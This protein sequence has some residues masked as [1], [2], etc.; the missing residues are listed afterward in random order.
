MRLL[1]N[2]AG[3]VTL[4]PAC[5]VPAEQ[6]SKTLSINVLGV[7]HGVRAFVPRMLES[8]KPA[9]IAN[10][11]S[12]GALAM[13]PVQT[14]YIIS[15]HAVLSFT[16]CLYLEMALQKKPIHVSAVVPGLVATRIFADA[17][18][19]RSAASVEGHRAYMEALLK[20]QGLTPREAGLRILEGIAAG[21][22]WVS[23]HPELTA[24]VAAARAEYLS[25]QAEPS[26]ASQSRAILE[27]S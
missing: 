14:P 3:I 11:T 13:M 19:D 16:E 26:I 22:F 15:K 24:Q 5:E 4:G 1:I 10:V 2:N 23:T 17:R 18:T 7:I 12:V 20:E 8:G 21:K 25:Q 9:Y 27:Q 6:W